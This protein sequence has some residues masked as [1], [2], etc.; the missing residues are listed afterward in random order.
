MKTRMKSH[1]TALLALVLVL[2][3]GLPEVLRAEPPI[4]VLVEAGNAHALAEHLKGKKEAVREWDAF[5]RTPLMRA[6]ELGRT[7]LVRVLLAAGAAPNEVDRRGRTALMRAAEMGQTEVVRM[8]LDAGAETD[9]E[10]NRGET[11]ALLAREAGQTAVVSTLLARGA[12]FGPR[13][14]STLT[15]ALYALYLTISLALTVWVARTLH[16]NG[17]IFLVD[18][19]RGNES[20]ADSVN[21]L[22]VVGFYLINIGYVTFALQTELIPDNVQELIEILSR[23][24]GVVLLILGAMHFFNIFMFGRLRKKTREHAPVQLAAGNPEATGQPT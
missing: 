15:L 7:D 11:A 19:F 9:R 20:L 5:R 12:R 16:K 17:R 10:N 6:V 22:L 23:K 1:P 18:A 4:F 2:G 13:H 21:H 14:W 8:L 3:L 24:V